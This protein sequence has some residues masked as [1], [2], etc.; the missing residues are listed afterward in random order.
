MSVRLL[1]RYLPDGTVV[2]L[3]AT[4]G[5]AIDISVGVEAQRAA[6]KE[7]QVWGIPQVGKFSD[8]RP[9]HPHPTLCYGVRRGAVSSETVAMVHP[10][11]PVHVPRCAC[12]QVRI[13]QNVFAA[14]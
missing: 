10:G 12:S 6:W 9:N 8:R 14:R 1:M 11:G 13:R 5:C 7:N 4:R 2:V 3:S